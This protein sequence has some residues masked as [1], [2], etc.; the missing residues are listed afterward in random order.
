MAST[1]PLSDRVRLAL[2]E[3]A[4]RVRGAVDGDTLGHLLELMLAAVE[5]QFDG[6]MLASILVLDDDGRRLRRGAAPSLPGAYSAAIDGLE[7]GP[8]VGSCGTAAYL[9]HAVYV[10]DIATDPLWADFRDLAAEHGLRAC[11]S[12]PIEGRSRPI[13]GTFAIYYRTPRSPTADELEAIGHIVGSAA[14]LIEEHGR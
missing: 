12:T 4:E 2:A 10:T 14:A 1:D 3:E 13:L 5:V 7:I 8:G 9:G 6:Q 11:W